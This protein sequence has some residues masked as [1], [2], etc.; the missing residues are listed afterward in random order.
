MTARKSASIIRNLMRITLHFSAFYFSPNNIVEHSH[1][2]DPAFELLWITP[3]FFHKFLNLVEEAKCCESWEYF[4]LE[5]H[6]FS[7]D[8]IQMFQKKTL[9][10]L[11]NFLLP[12]LVRVLFCTSWTEHRVGDDVGLGIRDLMNSVTQSRPMC[13]LRNQS[14]IHQ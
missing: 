12:S 7:V 9:E 1:E 6:R 11:L 2:D 13:N 14:L 4:P 8:T 5:N 3:S 10:I